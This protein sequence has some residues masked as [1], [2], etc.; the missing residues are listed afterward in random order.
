MK[1]SIV[2]SLTIAILSPRPKTSHHLTRNKNKVI[3][4]AKKTRMTPKTV[5]LT[6]KLKL[7]VS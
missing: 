1:K 6:W 4:Q 2:S 3:L 5:A 7:T